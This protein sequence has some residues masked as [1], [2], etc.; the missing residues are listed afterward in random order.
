MLVVSEI[1]WLTAKR[2]PEL[3]THWER[4]YPEIDVASAKL[5]MLER[6]G[7][8]PEAYFVLPASCWL[9][10]YYRPMQAR[11]D[12]FLDRHAQS[13]AARTIVEAEQ[14]EIALYEQYHACYGYSFYIARKR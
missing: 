8:R 9:E 12:D 10:N 14:H 13:D 5:R 2:P 6:H 3:Q 11:F 4:V 7:Y 1:T